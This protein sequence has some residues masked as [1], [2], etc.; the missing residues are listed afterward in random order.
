M[1]PLPD[2]AD[3]GSA[4]FGVPDSS[5][6]LKYCLLAD[7]PVVFQE[8]TCGARLGQVHGVRPRTWGEAF[9]EVLLRLPVPLLPLNFRMRADG[10]H[11]QGTYNEEVRSTMGA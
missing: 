8:P 1:L 2:A 11:V 10:D 3:D 7:P 9:A 4:M 6:S 5:T